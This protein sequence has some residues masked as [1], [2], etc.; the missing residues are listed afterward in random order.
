MG[1]K[2]AF[3]MGAGGRAACRNLNSGKI[4]HPWHF[5]PSA[6]SFTYLSAISLVSSKSVGVGLDFHR[7]AMSE[8]EGAEVRGPPTQHPGEKQQF[9]QGE[10]SLRHEQALGH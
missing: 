4:A 2:T 10:S 5:F 1:I 9:V 7:K 8:T 6:M 3:L